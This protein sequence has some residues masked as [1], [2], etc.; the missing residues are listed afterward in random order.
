MTYAPIPQADLG[1]WEFTVTVP[2]IDHSDKPMVSDKCPNCGAMKIFS[3]L[4]CPACGMSYSEAEDI[5]KNT[6]VKKIQFYK[7]DSAE[8]E[9]YMADNKIFA[10]D[11]SGLLMDITRI[12]TEKNINIISMN[13]RTSKQG[14]A[15]LQTSFWIRTR[16]ELDKVIERLNSIEGVIDI[17]RTTN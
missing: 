1:A 3:A 2:K 12:F 7:D 11:R 15:T 10:N 4:V 17:E 8:E 5:K 9:K 13:T 14:V 16:E 6:P